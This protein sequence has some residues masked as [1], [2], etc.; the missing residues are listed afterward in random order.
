MYK[1]KVKIQ[2]DTKF[3]VLLSEYLSYS[4]IMPFNL[5]KMNA[6]ISFQR[7]FYV[8]MLELLLI[9]ALILTFW[10]RWITVYKNYETF[11]ILIDIIDN[12]LLF[13]ILTIILINFNF[14]YFNNWLNLFKTMLEVDHYFQTTLRIEKSL[15]KF[16]FEAGIAMVTLLIMVLYDIFTIVY[17]QDEPF[18]KFL[19]YFH[20]YFSTLLYMPIFLIIFNILS[21]IKRRFNHLNEHLI[22]IDTNI[23]EIFV[24]DE[25]RTITEIYRKLCLIISHFNTIFGWF[26]FSYITYVVIIIVYWSYIIMIYNMKVFTVLSYVI[27][28]IPH[29]VVVSTLGLSAHFNNITIKLRKTCYYLQETVQFPSKMRGELILAAA[30]M[31]PSKSC[32]TAADFYIINRSL[33]CKIFSSSITYIIMLSQFHATSINTVK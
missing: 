31:D 32:I 4:G 33:L 16:Y 15:K 8:I 21:F 25:I 12:F 29:L 6:E 1:E 13:A 17:V 11:E 9:P 2:N 10:R 23:S 30:Q 27:A 7:K 5:S 14:Y 24:I 20:Y 19:M 18:L 3:I 26:L 28:P 22:K